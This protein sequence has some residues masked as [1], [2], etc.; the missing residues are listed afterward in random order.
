[1]N[2]IQPGILLPPPRLA[3][4]L[5]FSLKPDADPRGSLR[6][7]CGVADGEQSVVG[8]GGSLLAAIGAVIEGLR[9]FPCH[10]GPGFDI[11]STPAAL[12]VWLRGD[13]RGELV[14]R[15]RR[16]E[17]AVS[18]AFH[19]DQVVDAFQ[20]DASRDLTGYEDGTENPKDEKA[21]EAAMV[22]RGAAGVQGSSFVAVQQWLHD[23]DRFEAMAPEE[24]DNAIGRRKRTN[25]EMEDAPPSA[26]IKRTAQ[27][28]FQPAAF[29]L[30]RSMPWADGTRAGLMFVAFGASLDAFEALLRRMIGAEDGITD[31]LFGFTRPLS[32]ATFW[33]P[34]MR[35]GRLDLSVLDL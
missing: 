1:M 10:A 11:P 25:E 34:G 24:Q 26:H 7:L 6:A 13:D 17:S 14:H 12:W 21:L 3:R 33:C 31:A 30:R 2:T 16:I 15:T 18:P 8:L 35:G 29:V 28:S 4:Y 22:R 32:G 19:L 5:T 23:L 20:Y 9:T 27:E